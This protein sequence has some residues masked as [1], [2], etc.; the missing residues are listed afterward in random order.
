MYLIILQSISDIATW[1]RYNAY[2]YIHIF[3]TVA[4]IGM[5]VAVVVA[6]AIDFRLWIVG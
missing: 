6:A 3:M 5:V 1:L 2:M 4:A